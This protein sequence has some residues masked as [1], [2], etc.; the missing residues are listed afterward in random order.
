MIYTLLFTWY[1]LFITA[2]T[3][4][5]DS[6]SNGTI[7]RNVERSNIETLIY[8]WLLVHVVFNKYCSDSLTNVKCSTVFL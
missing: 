8:H 6:Q 1:L 7:E 4:A 2:D 3:E 5:P